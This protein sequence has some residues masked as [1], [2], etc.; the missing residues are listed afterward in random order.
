MFSHFSMLKPGISVHHQESIFSVFGGGVF[1][2]NWKTKAN[3]FVGLGCFGYGIKK[4]NLGNLYVLWQSHFVVEI[5]LRSSQRRIG[6]KQWKH[7][8]LNFF[9]ISD[10]LV[11]YM[12]QLRI[13]F[14]EEAKR[15]RTN[16][17][18][19]LPYKRSISSISIWNVN[20]LSYIQQ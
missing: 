2:Y 15:F 9:L 7:F 8:I 14:F 17:D 18:V 4:S 6:W 19:E 20:S 10:D 11:I 3:F 16:F 1:L 5:F 12:S 13:F